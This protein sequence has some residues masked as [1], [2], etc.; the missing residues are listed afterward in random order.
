MEFKSKL[1]KTKEQD[2][3]QFNAS[4]KGCYN[5]MQ[6]VLRLRK[7]VRKEVFEK[8]EITPEKLQAF[9]TY[10]HEN[11]HWWQHIGSNFGFLLNSSYPSF[12]VSSFE[13]L[14]K[15]IGKNIKYKSLIK[16]EKNHFGDK[17][18][19]DIPELNYILNN[20]F[21]LE[22]AKLFAL[23]NKN[24]H[25]IIKDKKFFLNMGH[26]YHILWHTSIKSYANI[27]DRDFSLLPDIENWQEKFE[28]LENSKTK[29]SCPDSNY[30]ISPIGIKAIYEG[31]AIFNQILYLKYVFRK[32]NLIYKDFE[33]QGMLYGIYTEAFD[34]FLDI[35]D[36]TKPF[37]LD[38]PLIYLFLLICDISINPNNGFPLEIYDFENFISKNDP[39]IRFCSFTQEV[40]KNKG[41]YLKKCER[42]SKETYIEISKLLNKKIGC[43]CCY[44]SIKNVLAWKRNP[45]IIKVLEEEETHS[46]NQ[47]NL[48]FRLFF[49]KFIRYQEDK[50]KNPHIFCWIGYYLSN[51]D[52][53]KVINLFDKHI[54]LFTDDSSDGEIKPILKKNICQENLYNTFNVFYQ[55]TILYEII[56]KWVSEE[57]KFKLDYKWLFNQRNEENIP[58]IKRLFKDHFEIDLE[59]I[60]SF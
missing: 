58:F 1:L 22:Y 10:I 54:A 59:E 11:I 31:Q 18:K 6:F 9:S 5:T 42:P 50:F 13:T 33:D 60:I 44:S 57:G 3:L 20:F 46:F 32:N 16:Y 19:C 29:G 8:T 7:D 15:L 23:D 28:Q 51:A 47:E 52:T 2:M 40:K 27:I 30:H 41:Y 25:D 49:S 53:D 45:E 36:E 14:K 4:Y 39:G 21:D 56:L 17:G 12:A 43:K 38:D 37:F 24:I 55:N 35:L 34:L 48:P 26:C